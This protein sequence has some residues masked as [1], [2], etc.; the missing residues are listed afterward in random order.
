MGQAEQAHIRVLESRQ[1]LGRVHVG[2]YRLLHVAP[3][4]R[5]RA[6]SLPSLWRAQK[7]MSVTPYMLYFSL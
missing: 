1:N 4:F 7:V 6:S 2:Y 3:V 5:P